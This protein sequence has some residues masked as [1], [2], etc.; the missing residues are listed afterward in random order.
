MLAREIEAENPESLYFYRSG[1][2]TGKQGINIKWERVGLF[3]RFQPLLYRLIFTY[4]TSKFSM[5]TLK[6]GRTFGI[7]CNYWTKPQFEEV[8]RRHFPSPSFDRIFLTKILVGN[9]KGV[10]YRTREQKCTF[11]CLWHCLFVERIWRSFLC[12]FLTYFEKLENVFRNEQS[13]FHK[14]PL[15]NRKWRKFRCHPLKVSK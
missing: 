9:K 14:L 15:T 8:N 1:K 10:W 7:I 3:A 11:C 6:W 13:I 12:M 4:K 2:T 5:H